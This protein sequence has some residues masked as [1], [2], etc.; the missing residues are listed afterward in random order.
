M[1][2]RARFQPHRRGFGFLTPVAEDGLTPEPVTLADAEGEAT[3]VSRVFAPPPVA[4]A[5]VADD[6]VAADV[7]AD[8]KGVA[9]S[10]VEVLQRPRRLLVGTVGRRKSGQPIVT[11][12]PAL[13]SGAVALAEGLAHELAGALD[14]Q[15]VLLATPGTDGRPVAQALVA[16][17]HPATHPDAIRAR[18]VALVLGGAA[19]SLVPGGPQAVGLDAAA[20][21]T[22]HLRL[23]GQLAAGR[24]GSA[25]G[26]DRC[27]HVPGARLSP[28]DRRDE[29]CVT[30]DAARSRE[31]DDAVGASWDGRA[32][33]AVTVAVH[34]TDVAGAVGL[35]SPADLHARTV[36]ATAYLASS[37]SAPMLDPE[38]SEGARSLV[39][40]QDRPVLSVRFAVDASGGVDGVTVEHAMVRSRAKLSYGAVEQW[41]E[42]DPKPLRTQARSQ[43]DA[44]ASTVAG[45]LEA[46][47]RL[48]VERDARETLEDLFEPAELTPTVEGEAVRLG[49]AEPHAEA[50][51]LI[52][53]VMVA[54]NEAVGDWLVAHEVPALYRAH[55]G[56]DPTRQARLRAAADLTGERLPAL[57]ADQ[58]DPDRVAGQILGAVHD[59]AAQG[60][61]ADRDLLIA[62]ATGA[63]ARA[64]YDPDPARH[65]GLGTT[66]YTHFTSPLRRYADLS[67]HRQIRAVLAGEDPPLAIGDLEALAVWLGARAGALARLEA[68]ERA[69][70]WTRLLELGELT[71]TETATVTGLSPAGLRIRLPR[72]GL[73]GFIL[74]E[75]ALG[76]GEEAARL[77]VDEHGLRTTSG[78]WRVGARIAVRFDGRD[79]LGR[80]AWR[81]VGQ[82]PARPA[83]NRHEG[84]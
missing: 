16:G 6:L 51:R 60:R 42:G 66:A 12:D 2:L 19:P 18:A 27:G 28:V 84:A 32:D 20:A 45:I 59:L 25:A 37:P 11:P 21:E 40:G 31:L 75:Q 9:A 44:A 73:P 34:I 52:E 29:P 7:A 69:D 64:T 54:A 13:G 38:L 49:L 35:G 1:Q 67:V 76:T 39:A 10:T 3:T 4:R 15:V 57:D 65:R 62:A 55:E 81:L 17:P 22:T 78:Q 63:T 8:A 24:R 79:H 71:G 33:S 50:F 61:T 70:L 14:E 77:E 47:R 82:E 26:L 30:I 58:G 74:A 72:L 23:M 43:A 80:A 68:R 5:L 36:A 56:I 46:A 41:L 48:G 53:R 83:S